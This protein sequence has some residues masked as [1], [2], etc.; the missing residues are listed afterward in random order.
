[1]RIVTYV[2]LLIII[3]IGVTFAVLNPAIVTLNYYIGQK[4]LPLSLLTV[5]VFAFGCFLGLLVGGWLFLKIKIKNIRL[6][7]RLKVAEKEV[8]NLRAIPLQDKH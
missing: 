6:K 5:S 4:T 2:L 7:Q 8:Q 1:M 3:L